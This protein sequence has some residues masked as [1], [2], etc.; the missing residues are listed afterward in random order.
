MS[1]VLGTA[2]LFSVISGRTLNALRTYTFP[3]PGTYS[4]EIAAVT[5]EE[6]S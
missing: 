2:D 3:Q 1:Q 6:I 4:S 5:N